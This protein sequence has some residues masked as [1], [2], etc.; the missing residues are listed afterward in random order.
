MDGNVMGR[1][2]IDPSNAVE[3]S[4][5]IIGNKEIEVRIHINVYATH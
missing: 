3:G 1:T 4:R 5:L 2:K